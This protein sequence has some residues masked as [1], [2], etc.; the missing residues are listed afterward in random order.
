MSLYIDYHKLSESNQ[1]DKLI[2]NY[3]LLAKC[4]LIILLLMHGP[5][6]FCVSLMVLYIRKLVDDVYVRRI[7]GWGMVCWTLYYGTYAWMY[8]YIII[9]LIR[10]FIRFGI[11]YLMH[12][13][14]NNLPSDPI[15]ETVVRRLFK[16]IKVIPRQSTVISTQQIMLIVTSYSQGDTSEAFD[17]D[18]KSKFVKLFTDFKDTS[19]IYEQD[20]GSLCIFFPTFIVRFGNNGL[21]ITSDDAMKLIRG[22]EIKEGETCPVCQDNYADLSIELK[23]GHKYCHKCI[24]SWLHQYSCPSCRAEIK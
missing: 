13:F 1:L 18:E 16:V 23:C 14:G 7:L 19:F 12:K 24:F 20:T 8:I 17:N 9:E 5:T 15:L 3:I 4:P 10:E 11:P 21:Q 6:S 22:E 2:Y